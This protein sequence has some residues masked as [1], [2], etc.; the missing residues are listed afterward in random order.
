MDR[1]GAEWVVFGVVSGGL[2]G[3]HGARVLG[4]PNLGVHCA[5]AGA[6]LGVPLLTVLVPGFLGA[7]AGGAAGGLALVVGNVL[8]SCDSFELVFWPAVAGAAVGVL[9]GVGS[10]ARAA[11]GWAV[12]LVD[13]ARTGRARRA[14]WRR[15]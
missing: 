6:L 14:P 10:V 8:F 7:V 9:L 13:S 1:D 3:W 4:Y 5:I 11:V 2:V 15:P 12:G